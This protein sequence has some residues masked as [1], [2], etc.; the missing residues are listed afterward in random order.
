MGHWWAGAK[1]IGPVL[2]RRPFRLSL[3]S[4]NDFAPS[5]VD[6]YLVGAS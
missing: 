4:A 3:Q 2:R 1:P 6:S 5:G